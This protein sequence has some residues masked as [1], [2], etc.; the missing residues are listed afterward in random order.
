MKT[1]LIIPAYKPDEK[2]LG[3][4]ARFA[5]NDAFAPVVVDDGSGADCRAIF[6]AL[7]A[8]VTLLRHPQNRGKGAALKTAFAHVL[9]HMPE[10][11]QAVTAEH[12][13]NMTHRI[14]PGIRIGNV[15]HRA[16]PGKDKENG[17]NRRERC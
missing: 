12:I 11:D 17:I 9:A 13:R 7:P 4:L 6:D 3:L 2:L 8:G 5:G 1:A 14:A 15:E 10:C 16:A